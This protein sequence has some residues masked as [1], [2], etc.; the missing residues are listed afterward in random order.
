[1]M[2][3]SCAARPQLIIARAILSACCLI[4]I[5]LLSPLQVLARGINSNA[6]GLSLQVNV[7]FNEN[8]RLNFLTP[9]RVTLNNSG[10][11]FSGTLSVSIFSTLKGSNFGPTTYSPWSF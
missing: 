5:L 3:K 6:R 11:D 9:V 10:P 8:Y 4:L 1:M 7:G 2:L